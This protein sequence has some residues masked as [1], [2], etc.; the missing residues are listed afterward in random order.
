MSAKAGSRKSQAVRDE[1]NRRGE[2]RPP[3]YILVA[4][5]SVLLPVD[6]ICQRTSCFCS[7]RA[8]VLRNN[9]S[10][11]GATG[12]CVNRRESRLSLRQSCA[13]AP[14][15][16]SAALTSS[17]CMISVNSSQDMASSSTS[18]Q[19]RAHASRASWVMWVPPQ[20]LT[21]Q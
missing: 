14:S 17:A 3:K 11:T 2:T 7:R 16:S 20:L 15:V 10:G 19:L 18:C 21:Y 9:R 6:A 12:S 13:Y 1:R 4:G 5:F 8:P